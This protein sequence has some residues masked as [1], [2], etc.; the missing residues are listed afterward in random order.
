MDQ[1]YEYRLDGDGNASIVGCSIQQEIIEIPASLDGHAVTSIAAG[2]FRRAHRTRQVVCPGSLRVIE[3]KAFEGC[4]MLSRIDLNEGLLR[5]GDGAFSL[6]FNLKR[7]DVPASLRELGR[8]LT[9]SMAGHGK[10]DALEIRIPAENG[11]LRLDANGILYERCEGGLRVVDASRCRTARPELLAGTVE[12][13]DGAFARNA[14]LE[15]I[16][17]PEG[18]R[19]VGEGA[20][21]CCQNLW[22]V[23]LPQTLVEIRDLAFS[24]TALAS[25]RIPAACTEL[26]P[27]A[28]NLGPVVH[29]K[30]QLGYESP[31]RELAVD[32][33]NPVLCQQGPVLYR[34]LADGGLEAL[35]CPRDVRQ[36]RVPD[37]CARVDAL[38]FAGTRHIGQLSLPASLRFSERFELLPI[39]RCD[40]I[41]IRSGGESI[42]VDVPEGDTGRAFCRNAFTGGSVDARRFFGAYDAALASLDLGLEKAKLLAA[43]LASPD[44]LEPEAR[45]LFEGVLRAALPSVCIRFGECGHWDGFDQLVEA[46]LLDRQSVTRAV[47]LLAAREDAAS[48][49]YLLNMQHTAF[50]KVKW[51]YEL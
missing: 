17:L 30:T 39:C 10:T 35:A 32:P 43:R 37:A 11:F 12:V 38:C 3:P 25:L 42:G 31:L 22:S 34:R 24:Q 49:G 26:A 16:A 21:L 27:Q 46:G 9:G 47:G 5:I 18:V 14:S 28:L 36:V 6:C 44:F 29:G 51:D 50:G 13:G 45:G 15:A 20:F 7:L 19:A 33:A 23:G 8:G 40:R 2:A 41:E 1:E 48:A 4:A